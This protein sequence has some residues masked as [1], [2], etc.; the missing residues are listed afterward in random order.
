MAARAWED[1][2]PGG[3]RR[4]LLVFFFVFLVI[5]FVDEVAIFSG[6]SFVFLVVLFVQI[7]GDKV[8]VGGMRL[9]DSEFGFPLGTTQHLPF[10]DFL[11]ADIDFGGTFR[12][13]A[14]GSTLRVVVCEVGV[15]G[16]C[17]PL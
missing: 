1:A 7:I 13:P 9:R 6:L 4:S 15:R 12:A 8:Q 10:F 11:F 14:P 5:L 3:T 16:S 17:S 2:R